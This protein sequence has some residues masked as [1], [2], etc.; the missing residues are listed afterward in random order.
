MTDD[1]FE[2]YDEVPQPRLGRQEAALIRRD[3]DDLAAFRHTFEPEGFK[4]VSLF[5]VDC[6]EEHYY[7]W[8][9]L[10][11]NLE[12]LLK[13]GETP[14]HEPAFDPK[15]D[16][17]VNWEY[18][19]GYLDGLADGGMP[20]LPTQSTSTGGCPFCGAQL[21]EAHDN[22]VF[23]PLCGTHL[24][25]ARIARALLDRGWSTEDVTDLLRGAR[26]PPMLGL[27]DS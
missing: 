16:E 1:D 24:G 21:P 12:E 3:L 22:I 20:A 6:A 19:Q 18:A 25:P 4:G 9:M 15:P 17:Y 8:Q 13:S 14:V 23:C 27:T 11:H 2:E 7:E 5:C 10:E 26:I